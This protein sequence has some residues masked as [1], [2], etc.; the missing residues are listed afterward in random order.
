MG[1]VGAIMRAS[2]SIVFLCCSFFCF[3]ARGEVYQAGAKGVTAPK[4]I[5]RTEAL[6]TP[7]ARK[8]KIRGTVILEIEVT[9]R[10]NAEGITVVKSLDSGLDAQAIIA[11]GHWKFS[12]GEKDGKPVRVRALVEVAFRLP[13][14]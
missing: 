14:N 1:T 4:V 9:E 7:E 2:A 5:E 11:V 13:L 8:A 12:P 3:E 6:Y 10:G